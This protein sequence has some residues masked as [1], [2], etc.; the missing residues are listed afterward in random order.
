MKNLPE[1]VI[2]SLNRLPILKSL[3]SKIIDSESFIDLTE[4]FSEKI[5]DMKLLYRGSEHGFSISEFRKLCERK[6]NN[7]SILRTDSAKVIGA[8]TPIAWDAAK[9]AQY[10]NDPSLKTFI[11]S[12]TMKKKF[13]Q[14]NGGNQSTHHYT[15][16]GPRFGA[17]GTCDLA[18]G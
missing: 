7:L 12:L 10:G 15:N 6:E 11:F 1:T 4:M 17:D 2:K 14:T 8:F 18:I 9:N 16:W 5:T 3:D 13:V